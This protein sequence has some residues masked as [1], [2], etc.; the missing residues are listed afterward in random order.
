LPEWRRSP[1][2]K[3]DGADW[4]SLARLP[5]GE[6]SSTTA[7]RRVLTRGI[8]WQGRPLLIS[9]ATAWQEP[10]LTLDLFLPPLHLDL[11]EPAMRV[12]AQGLRCQEFLLP[13][14]IAQALPLSAK[15]ADGWLSLPDFL[16]RATPELSTARQCISSP[17]AEH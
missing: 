15:P 10:L 1:F 12:L 13:Q 8:S 2:W 3:S 6:E 16:R 14:R 17:G 11:P 4:E 7:D 5:F 9:A